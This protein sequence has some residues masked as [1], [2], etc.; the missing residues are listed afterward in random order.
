MR[1]RP[2]EPLHSRA[3]GRWGIANTSLSLAPARRDTLRCHARG[4]VM[5]R[6]AAWLCRTSRANRVTPS[7]GQLGTASLFQGSREARELIGSSALPPPIGCIVRSPIRTAARARSR[8]L[9]PLGDVR[10]SL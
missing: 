3:G 10:A 6:V 8:P 7:R 9:R 2:R 4:G 5:D 1:A